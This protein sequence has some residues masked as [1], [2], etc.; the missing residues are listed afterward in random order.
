MSDPRVLVR[1]DMILGLIG[2]IAALL[3]VLLVV[4]APRVGL[5]AVLLLAAGSALASY[6]YRQARDEAAR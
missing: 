2:L 1:L 5:S 4:E 6:R 3:S